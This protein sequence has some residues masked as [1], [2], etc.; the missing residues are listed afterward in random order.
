MSV[1]WT[2]DALPTRYVVVRRARAARASAARRISSVG[3]DGTALGVIR[4]PTNC[5]VTRAAG[6]ARACRASVVG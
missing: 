1:R 3:A 5:I 2:G 4:A 6:G